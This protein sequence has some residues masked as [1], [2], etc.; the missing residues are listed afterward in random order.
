MF[1]NPAKDDNVANLKNSAHDM[2]V[3]LH[4]V[5]NKAG[6]KVRA[7]ATSASDEFTH[8]SNQVTGEIRSNPIRSSAIALGV[9]ML[10]GALMRR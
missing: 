9:G 8:V 1:N 7:M 3:D 2:S 6:R 4:E 5:A 10:L